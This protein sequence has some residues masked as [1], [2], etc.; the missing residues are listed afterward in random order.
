MV[1]QDSPSTQ[2]ESVQ[3]GTAVRFP[4]VI[5][6]SS[7]L[8]RR[9]MTRVRWEL[10]MSR[11]VALVV[12]LLLAAVLLVSGNVADATPI[13]IWDAGP[14]GNWTMGGHARSG[15]Q[16]FP[17]EFAI[18][19]QS[20][21]GVSGALV[22]ASPF[23]DE[24]SWMPDIGWS[25]NDSGHGVRIVGMDGCSE[26]PGGGATDG[27]FPG[28]GSFPGPAPVRAGAFPVPDPG[29]SLLLFGTALAGLAT[30]RKWRG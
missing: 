9:K 20:K 13:T 22:F 2:V 3:N 28:R 30:V 21:G 15:D 4:E 10:P 24:T 25:P 16:Y 14:G 8:S 12:F 23:G 26:F 27:C 17:A 6:S 11:C 5:A 7:R 19:S 1:P 18:T 29:S